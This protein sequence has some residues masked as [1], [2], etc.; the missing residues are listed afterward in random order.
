MRLWLYYDFHILYM[1]RHKCASRT[2]AEIAAETKEKQFLYWSL[3][4]YQAT[5]GCI[6][7]HAVVDA[8]ADFEQDLDLLVRGVGFMH[9]SPPLLNPLQGHRVGNS[10]SRWPPK[11][12][13]PV[14]LQHTQVV[15]ELLEAAVIGTGDVYAGVEVCRHRLQ[16]HLVQGELHHGV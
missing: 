1:K 15:L 9:T 12:L 2:K 16:S 7:T 3:K 14:L 13:H 10:D 4:K 5:W 6:G 11:P 8:L